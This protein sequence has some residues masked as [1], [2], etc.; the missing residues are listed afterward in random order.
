[1]TQLSKLIAHTKIISQARFIKLKELLSQYR[2]TI[3][4]VKDNLLQNIQES[5]IE[6]LLIMARV[7]EGQ[8]ATSQKLLISNVCLVEPVKENF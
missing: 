3:K 2:K 8:M 1:M 5:L 6:L 4:L 7:Q